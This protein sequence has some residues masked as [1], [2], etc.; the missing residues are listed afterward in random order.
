MYGG[1]VAESDSH[2]RPEVDL[3]LAIDMVIRM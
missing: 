1:G 2:L 3:G